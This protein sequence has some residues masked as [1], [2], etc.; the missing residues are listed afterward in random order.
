MSA[1]SRLGAS[2]AYRWMACPGSVRLESAMPDSSSSYAARGTAAHGLAEK[3]QR[4]GKTARELVRTLAYGPTVHVDGYIIVLEDEDVEAVEV[5][6]AYLRTVTGPSDPVVIEGRVSLAPFMTPAQR[7]RL[8]DMFGTADRLSYERST[9]TLHSIDYKHG[10]GVAVEAIDNPQPLYYAAGA[11]ASGALGFDHT[12]YP[13]GLR[14]RATIVQPRCPHP[15]GPVRSVD[16]TPLDL[17][18]FVDEMLDAAERTQDPDAPLVPGGWCRFCS[19]S[20]T[21]PAQFDRAQR[22][23]K[24]DFGVIEDASDYPED[25]LAA[26]MAEVG[27]IE[28]WCAAVR[29]AAHK[30]LATGAPVPGWKL[31]PK[32]GVRV[33]NDGVNEKSLREL[34]LLEAMVMTPPAMKSVF[35]VEKITPKDK[36]AELAAFYTTKSSGT[37][38]APES[39]PRPAADA[40]S[41]AEDFGALPDGYD[42]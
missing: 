26:A 35:Q 39:D 11:L 28:T 21:C 41:A 6:L 9:N 38:I 8:P 22:A 5:Y 37:T 15:A 19:V 18:M 40:N 32:R 31:V 7:E 14:V 23:A 33:W 20:A 12:S 29:A 2:S 34:G 13:P 10:A 42:E 16:V 4:T 25:R 30:R 24:D 1:H 27:D 36:R 3:A 17:L